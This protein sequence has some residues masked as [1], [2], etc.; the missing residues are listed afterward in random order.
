[1]KLPGKI[2]YF[3]L[4]GLRSGK[5]VRVDEGPRTGLRAVPF[6]SPGGE[7]EGVD[8]GPFWRCGV[9]QSQ[10]LVAVHRPHSLP[11]PRPLRATAPGSSSMSG[12][13]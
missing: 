5:I 12:R 11:G 3:Q 9:D 10:G 1:M 8:G 7:G 4:D 13:T 2:A 6:A